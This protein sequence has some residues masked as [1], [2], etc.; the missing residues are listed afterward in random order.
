MAMGRVGNNQLV[1]TILFNIRDQMAHEQEL[2][3][4]I[5]SNKR[6][7]KPSMDPFGLNKAL[8]ARNQLTANEEY[9]DVI[10]VGEF[11]TNLSTA[12]IDN[13]VDTWK[14]V[15]EL[16]ISA[17]DGTKTAADRMVMA[18]EL[19]QLLEH[20]VQISNTTNGQ[21]YIFSGSQTNT[22]PFQ[23]ERHS[24]TGRISGVFYQ[25]DSFSREVRSKDDG[26]TRLNIAG[27]NAG[28]PKS[29]GLFID[30]RMDINSFSTLIE[31]RDKLLD[32]DTIGISGNDGILQQI[33][34]AASN[35]TAVQ[36]QLGGAQE[37]LDLDRN[38]IIEQNSQL[39]QHLSEIEDA[40]VAQLILELNNVQNVYEAALASGGR[41][42][43]SGLL[44]YI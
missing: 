17:A 33:D 24:N 12:T 10:N 1:R 30:S 43:K 21:R 42:I 14:R 13:V 32:N 39:K 5:S 7:L 15:N 40:D 6:I 26:R 25:G 34:R 9:E 23:V 19:E 27:S 28:D 37:R 22:A 20:M 2:F 35:F 36:V 16:A 4:Q 18:E 8:S 3:E 31:L 29:Q 11:W 41:L 38:R 44:N